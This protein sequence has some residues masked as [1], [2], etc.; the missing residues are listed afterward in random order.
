VWAG[1]I[2]EGKHS[3]FR[4]AAT[5]GEVAAAAAAVESC[6]REGAA[7]DNRSV[8]LGRRRTMLRDQSSMRLDNDISLRVG[9]NVE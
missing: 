1:G 4:E 3:A 2:A 9:D 8:K 7:G 6:M 5:L